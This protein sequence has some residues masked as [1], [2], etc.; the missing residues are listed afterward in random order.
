MNEP[1]AHCGNIHQ[2]NCPRIKAIEYFADG[3]VKRVEYHAPAPITPSAVAAPLTYLTYKAP[4]PDINIVAL[5]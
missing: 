5:N 2:G 1:C 3:A 4:Q